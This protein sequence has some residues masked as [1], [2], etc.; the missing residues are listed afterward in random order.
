M[1]YSK[2]KRGV[3]GGVV[4]ER[5]IFQN[6]LFLF[7]LQN[8]SKISS[9]LPFPQAS[10]LVEGYG[11]LMFPHPTSRTPWFSFLKKV[12]KNG[13]AALCWI[14]QGLDLSWERNRGKQ[15][16]YNYIE[17]LKGFCL[18]HVEELITQPPLRHFMQAV[19]EAVIWQEGW[20]SDL[21]NDVMQLLGFKFP[22]P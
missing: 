18:Q 19:L 7:V 8:I 20:S 22:N 9:L 14:S 10:K 4:R 21:S 5:D 2:I 11:Q 17:Q 6:H 15:N 12:T 13:R 16:N 3:G 1:S